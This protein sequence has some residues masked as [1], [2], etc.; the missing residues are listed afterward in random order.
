MR[1]AA[2]IPVKR[3]ENAKTRLLLEKQSAV[4]QIC[5][6]MLREV[7]HTVTASPRIMHTYVV[8]GDQT[9]ARI[10]SEA[11]GQGH[12]NNGSSSSSSSVSVIHDAFEHGV[13][14]AVALADTQVLKDGYDASIVIPQDI[15]YIKPQ[16]IDFVMGFAAP[17]NFAIIVPSR[18]FDGTNVLV[19]MPP[20]LMGTCYDNNDSY[21]GHVRMAGGATRNAA[22]VFVRRIMMDVDTQDDII[23]MLANPEKPHVAKMISSVLTEHGIKPEASRQN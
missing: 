9:A 14:E 19:R 23:H 11:A 20:D 18:K 4:S 22:P 15:P 21:R 8:T 7:L 5:S 1:T 2:I 16:D 10:A 13:N 6:I 17:P 3:F 12:N